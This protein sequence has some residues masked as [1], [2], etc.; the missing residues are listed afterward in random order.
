MSEMSRHISHRVKKLSMNTGV[1]RKPFS[2]LYPKVFKFI[3]KKIYIFYVY[4]VNC[5]KMM[6]TWN[7]FFIVFDNRSSTLIYCD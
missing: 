3:K 5:S 2:P 7:S 1:D 4:K 6:R